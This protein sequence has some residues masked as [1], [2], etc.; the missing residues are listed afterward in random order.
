MSDGSV[1]IE[2]SLDDKKADKQLDAFEKDL[3]K[4]ELTRGRH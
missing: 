4:Q 2:I 3:E 1:V